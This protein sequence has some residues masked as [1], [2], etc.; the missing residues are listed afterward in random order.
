M[1]RYLRQEQ[2]L[3]GYVEGKGW[4]HAVAH[5]GDVLDDLAQCREMG[6]SDLLEILCAISDKMSADGSPYVHEE[7]ER[8]TTAVMS[9]L[10]RKILD[11][12][13]I[14]KW[15]QEF[16]AVIQ[17]T[18][19]SPSSYRR[20]NGKN[21][22]RSLYFRMHKENRNETMIQTVYEALKEIGS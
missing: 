13:V 15:V 8:M 18:K 11:D 6:S 21:F 19:R 1:I 12:A 2:D 10:G 9:V 3:R 20:L 4:A 22:L 16:A 5:A 7:D 17:G 14:E